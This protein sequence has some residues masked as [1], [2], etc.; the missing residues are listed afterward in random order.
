[1]LKDSAEDQIVRSLEDETVSDRELSFRWNTTHFCKC[2]I[3]IRLMNE[4]TI[5]CH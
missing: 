4:H 3:M 1:M 2:A 5:P